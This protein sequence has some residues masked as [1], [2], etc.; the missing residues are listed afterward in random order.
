MRTFALTQRRSCSGVSVASYAQF[1]AR[2]A[3]TANLL[4]SLGIGKGDK[5]ATVLGNSREALGTRLAIPAV[6]AALVPLSPL[7]MPAGLASLLRD[8]DAK[9]LVSQSSMLATLEAIRTDLAPCFP[10]ASS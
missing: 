3:R 7:L 1:G 9:C 4:R 6:G 5:V 2:V 8:S 10:V